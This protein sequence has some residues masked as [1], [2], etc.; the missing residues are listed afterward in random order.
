MKL[1]CPSCGASLEF[2]FD[3][4][5]VRVCGS[6]RSAIARTDRGI[7]TL[8]QFADLA[9]SASGLA[10]GA[11]GRWQGQ[12]FVLVGRAEYA[13]PAGGS[14]EEWFMRLGDG[15]W[16]WLSHAHGTWAIT[17]RSP[18]ASGAATERA[19]P[20]FEQVVPGMRLAL[21]GG[22]GTVLTVGERNTLR[23]KSAEGELPFVIEP[24][25]SGRF[26]DASDEK[27]RFATLDYGPPGNP[28][29]PEA[30]LGR[31]TSL[32]ELGLAAVASEP[33]D[34]P[35][36]SGERL[37]CPHCGGSIELRVPERSLSVAC[38]YCGS[39]LDCE[40]PLA[41]LARQDDAVQGRPDLELGAEGTFEG[42]RYTV[43]GRLRRRATYPGGFVEW[44]EYLLYARAPGYRWLVCAQG[45]YSFVTPLAPG[46]VQEDP[47]FHARYGGQR[48]RVFDRGRA[49]V[50]GVWGEFYWKVTVGEA[51]D[52]A[53]YVGPPVMLSRES[54]ADELH[55]SLGVYTS[56]DDV[57]LAFAKPS[58]RDVQRGVAPHQPFRHRHWA[59]IALGLGLLLL[60]CM[61]FL[62]LT[63]D[64]RPVYSGQFR[65]GAASDDG[66]LAPA[67]SSGVARSPYVFFTPPFE[68]RGGSN[69]EVELEL[70]LQNDWAFVTV[71]L[72]HEG[73][74]ALRTYGAELSYYSGVEGGESWSEGSRSSSHLFGAGPDGSHVLR[75][76]VQTPQAST[77]TLT[78]KV[79]ENV[80]A[81]G[82]LGWVLALLGIPTAAL[83]FMHYAFERWRWSES[84]FAPRHLVSNSDD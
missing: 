49:E 51:V 55:W 63:S 26:V 67:R 65:L 84:D 76:E 15:R 81:F 42:A 14:W 9:P 60:A 41:I 59:P 11:A 39:I 50:T 8:G 31:R 61:L 80:F 54:T 73:S 77:Q 44:D 74:G 69:V 10:L 30:Y 6:C 35:R 64:N 1:F 56:L 7:D 20:S 43:T 5:F 29:P 19:L 70:P 24:G 53:D 17:F 57:R 3:D 22:E 62:A 28:E 18:S 79:A 32:S 40:G 21:G 12:P 4:S 27:G 48:F 68:L 36:A 71:D 23:L 2:R 16:A 33:T 13:H 25:A 82:Q 83:F 45:H 37:A 58:L 78:L 72:V 66:T 75:L 47:P 38:S 52:T 46:A 34:E